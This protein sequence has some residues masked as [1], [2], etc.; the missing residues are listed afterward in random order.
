[1]LQ[2]IFNLGKVPTGFGWKN[3][4]GGDYLKDPDVDGSI[5]LKLILEK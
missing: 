3:L 1:M 4:S 5:I 2:Y